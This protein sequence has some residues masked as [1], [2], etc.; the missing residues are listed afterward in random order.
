MTITIKGEM[1]EGFGKNNSRRVRR[2]GQIP[3]VLYGSG[4]DPVPLI[5]MKEDIFAIL[6][7]E[8]GENTIFKVSFKSE[9]R[10]AMIKDIQTDPV[11][12]ELLHT[13]LIQIALDKTI[14]VSVSV[15]L[16]GEA[17]GVKT[18]GGF[19]DFI[20]R[21]VEV[22]C[23]PKDIPENIQIDITE[24]HLH[25]SVKIADIA[26]IEGVKFL[27]DPH[28]VIV[29][30]EAPTKEEEVVAE[31]VEEGVEAAEEPEVLR[32]AKAGEETEPGK[33]E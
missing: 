21:E 18:E 6:K 9:T 8:S 1:R 27:S 23:L 14:R 7:S 31:E 25:Q 29:L 13:D 24:L 32:P 3:A 4:M 15:V 33:K 12:D 19:V 30:V 5:L 22:E 26:A 11:S 16:K 10:N 17:V 20:T 28:G 2:Q